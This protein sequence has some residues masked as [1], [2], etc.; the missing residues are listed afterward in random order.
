MVDRTMPALL[1]NLRNRVT[2][3]ERRIARGTFQLPGRLGATGAEV[4]DWNDA[5]NVGF[6]W[7]ENTAAHA[8]F[9][10]RFIGQV[11]VMGGDGPL[12]GRLVQEVRIPTTGT[13]G[14]LTWRRFYSGGVWS[15]WGALDSKMTGTAAQRLQIAPS[16]RYWDF[17][18]DTDTQKMMVGS[19]SGTWRQYAGSIVA[20][21]RAWDTTQSSGAVNLAGRTDSFTL[22]TVIEASEDIKVFTR[23][24]GNGFGVISVSVVTRNPTNTVVSLRLMQLMSVAQ[25]SYALG[26]EIVPSAVA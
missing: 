12:A 26:W 11:F 13:Q 15:A 19:K 10:D 9:A 14:Q 2:S 22:P 1:R 16:P 25:Q 18:Y 4:T 20:P 6:Y 3:L 7:S 23:S 24:V 8:P 5:V 17:W 21:T